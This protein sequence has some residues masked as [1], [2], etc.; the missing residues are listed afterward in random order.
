M[1]NVTGDTTKSIRESR[2]MDEEIYTSDGT[3]DIHKR[4]ANKEKTG[5]WKACRFIL[6]VL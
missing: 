3:R 2:S 4:P 6:G 1:I 5:N